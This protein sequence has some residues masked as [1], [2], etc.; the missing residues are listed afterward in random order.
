[1]APLHDVVKSEWRLNTRIL[2]SVCS[3]GLVMAGAACLFAPAD[4]AEALG[5]SGG[6]SLIVMLQ[7]T[8]ALYLAFAMA[9]WSAKGAM[10]GGIYSRPLSIANLL[11]F[12]VGALSLLKYTFS[13]GWQWPSGIALIIYVVFAAMFIYLVFGF[14]PGAPAA[15]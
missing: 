5:W 1:M 15:Q 14:S 8:G 7:L 2:M 3:I 6:P 11:H 12:T 10:I 4:F 9:N 13:Q